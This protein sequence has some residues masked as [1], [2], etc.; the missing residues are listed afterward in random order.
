MVWGEKKLCQRLKKNWRNFPCSK[1]LTVAFTG[2]IQSSMW[3]K[4]LNKWRI[5]IRTANAGLK[6]YDQMT[7]LQVLKICSETQVSIFTPVVQCSRHLSMSINGKTLKVYT[8]KWPTYMSRQSC[9]SMA[10]YILPYKLVNNKDG[11]RQGL[12]K[13]LSQVYL[14]HWKLSADTKKKLN[15]CTQNKPA[16]WKNMKKE[17]RVQWSRYYLPALIE[18]VKPD[19]G[20]HL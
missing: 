8:R 10:S 7:C 3:K 6:V 12:L 2:T 14:N 17:E 1:P 18:M 13:I 20:E 11:I 19:V 16:P 15:D 4:L 5:C 9:W